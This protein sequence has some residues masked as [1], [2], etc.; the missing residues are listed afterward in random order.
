MEAVMQECAISWFIVAWLGCWAVD[1]I[2]A[3]LRSPVFLVDPVVKL[4][5]VAIALVFVLHSMIKHGWLW[6]S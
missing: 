6:G 5:I 1:L 3:V 4:I 2:I